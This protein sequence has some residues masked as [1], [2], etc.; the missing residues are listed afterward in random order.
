MGQW[1]CEQKERVEQMWKGAKCGK[2]GRYHFGKGHE[3]GF[4]VVCSVPKAVALVVPRTSHA[5]GVRVVCV[6]NVIYQKWYL[7]RL[8]YISGFL[9]N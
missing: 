8:I 5:V 6:S 4:P 2:S 3:T 9:S 7:I 1:W